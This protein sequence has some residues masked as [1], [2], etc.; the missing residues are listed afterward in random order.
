MPTSLNSGSRPNVRASSG[1]MGTIL[2]PILGSRMRFRRSRPKAIV[3]LTAISEPAV[4]SAST[5][6]RGA[7]S[8]AARTTRRGTGPPRARRRSS[9]YWISGES[10]P[11]L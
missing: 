1:T 5:S 8:G 11:G 10:G 9:M 2:D 6:A 7:E 4:N 3:V